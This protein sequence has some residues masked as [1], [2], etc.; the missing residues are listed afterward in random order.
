MALIK[1]PECGKEVSDQAKI[2]VSCGFDITEYLLKMRIDMENNYFEERHK[3]ER[4]EIYDNIKIPDKPLIVQRI[5]M[6]L[7]L[8]VVNIGLPRL[9]CGGI[10]NNFWL[11]FFLFTSILLYFYVKII[12]EYFQSLSDFKLAKEDFDLYRDIVLKRKFTS[13]G[14]SYISNKTVPKCPTCGSAS[15]EQIK[16][17]SRIAHAAAFGLHSNTARSQFKCSNCGYKW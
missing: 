3:R 10:N 13:R 7:V 15:V 17:T 6:F 16:N 8:L 9:L 12:R 2:C 1:C 11:I 5:T 14:I 4:Q